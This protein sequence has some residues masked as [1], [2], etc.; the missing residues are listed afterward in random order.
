MFMFS[1]RKLSTIVLA[2]SLAM[3]AAG[4]K[5]KVPAPPPPA[6]PPPVA[7]PPVVR[8]A[9][10][11]VAQFTAEPTTIQRGQ[12]STLRWEGSGNV[13]SVSID[14]GI[15]TVQNTGNRRVTPSD[16]T[17]YTLTVTGPGGT[18]TAAATVSVAAPPPPP[19]PPAAAPAATLTQRME[20]ELSDAFFDYDKTD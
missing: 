4:C 15:G 18:T 14:Q 7:E 2:A 3:F 10:P 13:T 6:P 9:A 11:T 19:P 17:T 5:K 12:S 16:S 20:S 1:K 8:P